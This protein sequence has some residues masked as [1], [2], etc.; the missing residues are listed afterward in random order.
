MRD[1]E[2]EARSRWLL[3]YKGL[4]ERT[5]GTFLSYEAYGEAYAELCEEA[6]KIIARDQ[7]KHGGIRG[8]MK[9]AAVLD[10]QSG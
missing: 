5:K 6:F 2:A 10:D 8:R 3:K 4:Q 7:I 9:Q 1:V